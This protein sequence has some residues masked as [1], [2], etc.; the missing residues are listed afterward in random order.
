MRKSGQMNQR[1]KNRKNGIVR[2]LAIIL[3]ACTLLTTAG[4]AGNV[5]VVVTYGD[6]M[7]GEDIQN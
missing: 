4:E 3:L 5:L 2:M 1:K 6:K 7:H